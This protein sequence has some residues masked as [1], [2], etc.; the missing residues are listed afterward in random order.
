MAPKEIAMNKQRGFAT[1]LASVVMVSLV[2]VSVFVGQKGSVLEQ[3]SANNAYRTEEAFSNAEAGLNAIVKGV[4]DYITGNPTVASL[5]DSGLQA[6]LQSTLSGR[7]VSAG[8]VGDTV[9]VLGYGS[10]EAKRTVSQRISI[11]AGVN[12]GP[13]ALTA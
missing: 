1:L 11:A 2:T 12:N 7:P 10:G 9:Y 8:F 4:K 5:N 3:R 13:A 6:Y